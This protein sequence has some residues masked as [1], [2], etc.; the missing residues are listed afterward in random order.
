MVFVVHFNLVHKRDWYKFLERS[1]MV[2]ENKSRMR[3]TQIAFIHCL[4]PGSLELGSCQS[5]TE[6]CA[7]TARLHPQASSVCVS[8]SQGWGD[9]PAQIQSNSSYEIKLNHVIV[10]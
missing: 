10:W 1:M 6:W 3:L 7:V 2:K 5:A 4:S 8:Y 9:R